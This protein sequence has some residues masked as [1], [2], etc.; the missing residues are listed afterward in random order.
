MAPPRCAGLP[1]R[2][3]AVLRME[4][5]EDDLTGTEIAAFLREHLENM[6]EVTP[7]GSVYAYELERLRAPDVTFWSAWDDEQLLGCAAL[8]ELDSRTGEVK[9]MHTAA[10]YRR[11][12]VASALLDHLIAEAERRGYDHVHLE[13]GASKEFAPARA[14]Y[15]RHGFERRGR[16]GQYGDDPH[17]YFMTKK[18]SP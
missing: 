9:S 4:I 5:R 16:F 10:S 7:P 12:G 11:R 15:V 14:L 2:R 1:A 13:T 6:R 3:S 17:S 8:K 18:L